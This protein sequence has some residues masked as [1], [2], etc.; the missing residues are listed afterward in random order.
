MA[1]NLLRICI[2]GGST[3]RDSAR[4]YIGTDWNIWCVARIYDYVPYA[5]LV[6][7]MHRHSQHWTYRTLK[8]YQ[9]GKLIVQAPTEEF[10]NAQILPVGELTKQTTVLTSSFSWMIAHA[11]YCG[12]TEIALCGV[13][14]T[15]SS[16]LELQ[17]PGIFYAL[18]DARA[19]GVKVTVSSESQLQQTDVE[20]ARSYPQILTNDPRGDGMKKVVIIG[21]GPGYEMIRNYEDNKDYDIW[22]VP[23]IYPVLESHRV[24]KVF[25]VHPSLKWK[26]GI[27]YAAL[28]SK[29]MLAEPSP[30]TPDATIISLQSL[31]AKYGMVFSSSIA[32]MTG[33]ALMINAS[34]IVFLGV[35][36]DNTYS[37]QRDGLF[38]LLGFAKA[39]RINVVIPESSKLNIFGKSYGWI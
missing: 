29:L 3:G 37:G 27:D 23:T 30:N 11:L 17:R 15:H 28:G 31:Q 8:A 21:A 12:A 34:E 10:P 4:A 36:M 14:M 26:P 16:E 38:F 2:V 18:G 5:T 1:G 6:F 25:E 32:W 9:D 19:R 20:F 13:N 24:S 39:A 33:Y 35:D 22:C 7:E